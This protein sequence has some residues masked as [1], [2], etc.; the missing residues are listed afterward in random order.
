M[1]EVE[2]VSGDPSQE[3]AVG[4]KFS[5]QNLCP[6]VFIRGKYPGSRG[7]R[8]FSVFRGYPPRKFIAV[9]RGHSRSFAPIRG[10]SRSKKMQDSQRF[11]GRY[12]LDSLAP[13]L[14]RWHIENVERFICQ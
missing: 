11:P 6:S 2:I 12:H 3:T 10:Y 1:N 8:V 7:F 4:Q 5:A 9:I 14:G 13:R